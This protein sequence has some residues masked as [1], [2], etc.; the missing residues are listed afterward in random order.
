MTEPNSAPAKKVALKRDPKI[1]IPFVVIVAA[2]VGA[3]FAGK[4]SPEMAGLLLATLGFPSVLGVKTM[5]EVLTSLVAELQ[6]QLASI[7]PAQ[8]SSLVPPPPSLPSGV[9]IVE[10]PPLSESEKTKP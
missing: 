3:A 1:L 8:L 6:K 9:E 2:I 7:P 4:I 10:A 5:P